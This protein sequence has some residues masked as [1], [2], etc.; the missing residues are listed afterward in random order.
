MTLPDSSD[1]EISQ[2]QENQI[3]TQDEINYKGDFQGSFLEKGTICSYILQ[4]DEIIDDSGLVVLNNFMINTIREIDPNHF[5]KNLRKKKGKNITATC[6]VV[7]EKGQTLGKMAEE[8]EKE[9]K[10]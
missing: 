9:E 2:S 1:N 4:L 6:I 10:P 8:V 5:K 7:K 3:I